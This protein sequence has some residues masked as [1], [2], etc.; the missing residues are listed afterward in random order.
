MFPEEEQRLRKFASCLS[1]A[2][3]NPLTT[4]RDGFI[5]WQDILS[6]NGK[7]CILFR[8]YL[9]ARNVEIN[10]RIRKGNMDFRRDGSYLKYHQVLLKTGPCILNGIITWAR[11]STKSFLLPS[12]ENPF[13][14]RVASTETCRVLIIIIC[15]T[16]P[17][18]FMGRAF[19]QWVFG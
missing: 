2:K 18:P 19:A 8:A 16:I 6:A 17:D 5:S 1:D 14:L 7:W 11:R 12:R 3:N 15:I 9:R 13:E 10:I 4:E